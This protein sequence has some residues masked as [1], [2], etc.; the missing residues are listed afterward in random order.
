MN[1]AGPSPVSWDSVVARAHRRFWVR[2]AALAAIGAMGAALLLGGGVATRA[3]IQ[4][5]GPAPPPPSPPANGE[6]PNLTFGELAPEEEG[7]SEGEKRTWMVTVKNTSAVDAPSFDVVIAADGGGGDP[8]E[9]SFDPLAAGEK[10]EQKTFACPGSRASVEIVLDGE[11]EDDDRGDNKDT[12]ECA[13]TEPAGNPTNGNRDDDPPDPEHELETEEKA[14]EP[15][16]PA[17]E[18]AEE[19]AETEKEAEEEAEAAPSR[20]E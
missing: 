16:E 9:L 4:E 3:A 10:S 7:G 6:K 12:I 14:R 18:G 15:E 19:K 20:L 11:V 8:V 17:N 13:S 1:G 5:D 2:L